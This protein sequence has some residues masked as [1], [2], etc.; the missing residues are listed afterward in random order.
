MF[1]SDGERV[2]IIVIG[3]GVVGL[4]SAWFLRQEGFDVTVVE[5]HPFA[6]QE[7]SHANAGQLSYGY[8]MPWAAPGVPLKALKWLFDPLAPFKLRLDLQHPVEQ[9]AWLFRMYRNCD[10]TKFERNKA[11]MLAL[12]SFSKETLAALRQAQP[13]LSFDH[14]ARGTLQLFRTKEQLEAGR[15][16]LERL[17][18]SGVRARLLEDE[19]ELYAREPGLSRHLDLWGGLLLEGDETGDCLTFTQQLTE[20]AH[21]AG[22]DFVWGAEF[23]N[24]LV[25]ES[26]EVGGVLT[27]KGVRRG[28]RFVVAAGSHSPKVLA[29]LGYSLPVYPVKGYSL[30]FDIAAPERAPSSTV[31]DEQYKVAI[32]RLGS[33]VRVGGTAELTGFDATLRPERQVVLARSVSELFPG[34][35]AVDQARFWC[36]FRPSTPDSVPYIGPVGDSRI[37][38]NCGHGT[39]GWTMSCGSAQALALSMASRAKEV[40]PGLLRPL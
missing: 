17:Q 26:G 9:A 33:R 7:S 40:P 1:I 13:S 30:T 18:R 2:K 39:L 25:T 35:G 36:G 28:D 4:T 5:R 24:W 34:A 15:Q 8:A 16:D 20:L 6:A 14:Q 29:A 19:A 11:R 37:W 21:S 3:A 32:T 12:S 10:A 27:S 38:V 31:M 22:V 23:E